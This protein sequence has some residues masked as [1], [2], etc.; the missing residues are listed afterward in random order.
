METRLPEA[1]LVMGRRSLLG[2][3]AATATAAAATVVSPTRAHAANQTG[4]PEFDEFMDLSEILTDHEFNLRDEVGH[5][6]FE[7]LH[8]DPSLLDLVNRTV[9]LDDPPDTFAEVLRSGALEAD[10]NAVM[11]QQILTYWYSGIV[12]DQT[13]DYLEALAWEAQDFAT[14]PSTKLGF[15]KWEERP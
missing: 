2:G 1:P 15:P 5:Q 10:A 4:P 12:D 13:A 8:N 11:A 14:P 7:A 9:R 3:M 6:Y